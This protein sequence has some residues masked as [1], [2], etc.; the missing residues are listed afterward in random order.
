M[1]QKRHRKKKKNKNVYLKGIC[2]QPQLEKI[3]EE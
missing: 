3:I 1:H 2:Y